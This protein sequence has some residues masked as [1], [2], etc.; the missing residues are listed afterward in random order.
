RLASRVLCAA[1]VASHQNNIIYRWGFNLDIFPVVLKNKI[2]NAPV[3][4]T[5]PGAQQ[6]RPIQQT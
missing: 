2:M 5:E 4:R 1:L 3:V 6:A